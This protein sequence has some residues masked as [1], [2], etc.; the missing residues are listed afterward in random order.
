[1][2][3]HQDRTGAVLHP[4][5]YHPTDERAARAV[6]YFGPYLFWGSVTLIVGGLLLVIG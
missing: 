1:M 3:H 5:D 6:A 4:A 2:D